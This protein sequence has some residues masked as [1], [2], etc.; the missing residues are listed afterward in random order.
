MSIDTSSSQC[1]VLVAF[2]PMNPLVSGLLVSAEVDSS[3]FEPSQFRLV[4][5]ECPDM[6]LLPAG[7]QLAT[8]VTVTVSNNGVPTPL[9]TGEVTAVEVDYAHGETLTI[10]RGM[11]KSHRLMRGTATMAYPEMTA[12]DVVTM[13]VGQAGVIPGEIIPTTTIYPW[14][15]QANVSAWVF[16]Q[17]LAAMENCVAYADALGLFNFG[18]M[19]MPEAG[20]PPAVTYE[21]PTMGTQLVL[22]KNLLRLRAVVSA[23]EQV[24]LV[25]VTGYDPSAA[26]PVIGPSP[27]LPSTSQSMD[28]AT[29]PP[30]VAGEFGA[31][32]FFDASYPAIRN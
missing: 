18:P 30:V 22:G 13:L 14:L 5:R 3:M 32:P 4:F 16:I 2:A 12:S 9:I 15:S 1:E 27:T 26:I 28:P 21:T 25:T 29:L 20:M 31:M 11:D 19:P 23:N 6:V 24:P 7:L 10:V 8:P 17:Q